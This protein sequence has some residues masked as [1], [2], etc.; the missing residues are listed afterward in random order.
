MQNQQKALKARW[1]GGDDPAEM[2]RI[3]A[4]N[5]N[6]ESLE[7][8]R[9]QMRD[10]LAANPYAEEMVPEWYRITRSWMIYP[11]S[12]RIEGVEEEKEVTLNYNCVDPNYTDFI[13]A[14]M[15]EGRFSR[16]VNL[17]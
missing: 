2:E 11:K 15:E 14:K 4:F 17:M 5:L 10:M 8:I 3:Y 7:P 1:P 6:G 13:H 12:Y 16:P 9:K